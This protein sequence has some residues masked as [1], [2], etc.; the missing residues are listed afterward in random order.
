MQARV[1]RVPR[2]VV[3]QG[4][5]GKSKKRVLIRENDFKPGQ[6]DAVFP[7]EEP[8]RSWNAVSSTTMN[9]KRASISGR[10]YKKRQNVEAYLLEGPSKS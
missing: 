6:N 2:V 5:E 1:P 7:Q 9:R 10:S 8:S 3:E 4:P